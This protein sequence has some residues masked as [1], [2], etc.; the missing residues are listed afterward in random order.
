MTRH[1]LLLQ[2]KAH[3]ALQRQIRPAFLLEWSRKTGLCLSWGKG[4]K[5]RVILFWVGL[6]TQADYMLARILYMLS[7]KLGNGHDHVCY[8]QSHMPHRFLGMPSQGPRHLRCF[9]RSLVVISYKYRH[10]LGRVEY[11]LTYVRHVPRSS[12]HQ[13]NDYR[14]EYNPSVVAVLRDPYWFLLCIGYDY[15][16]DL[17]QNKNKTA[18]GAKCSPCCLI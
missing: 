6:F 4:V 17:K 7:H 13:N 8:I 11:N 9:E 16:D 1:T 3:Y 5:R 2:E 12:R 10:N 15:P 14:R 18:F